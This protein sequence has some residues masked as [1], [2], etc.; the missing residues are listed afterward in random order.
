MALLLAS[1]GVYGVVSYAT[2]QRTRE[3]GIR[4]ALGA[5]SADI[6]RLVLREAIVLVGL[7]LSLGALL[8]AGM[9]RVLQGLLYEVNGWNPLTFIAVS[10]LLAVVALV[11]SAVPAR[12]ATRI[13]PML[14]LRAE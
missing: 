8:A 3:F 13:D 10:A 6:A 11:A 9:T 7:G 2:A 1:I 14:A 12:R 5:G 4:S